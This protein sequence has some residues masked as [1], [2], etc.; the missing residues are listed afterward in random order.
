MSRKYDKVWKEIDWTQSHK[1][2]KSLIHWYKKSQNSRKL[3]FKSFLHQKSAKRR[4]CF[5]QMSLEFE[6]FRIPSLSSSHLAYQ[7][8]SRLFNASECIGRWRHVTHFLICFGQSSKAFLLI[9]FM[10]WMMSW[11][12]FSEVPFMKKFHESHEIMNFW[13]MPQTI[14]RRYLV[15]HNLSY[16]KMS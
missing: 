10:L 6:Y 14:L 12:N 8:N 5:K 7:M 1:K 4:S 3:N 9:S 15:E 11:I 2:L 13:K 16:R